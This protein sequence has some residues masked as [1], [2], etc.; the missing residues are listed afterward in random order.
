MLARYSAPIGKGEWPQ[1][2]LKELQGCL[3]ADGLAGYNRLYG[4]AIVEVAR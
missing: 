1:E 4:R 3:Q 2:H